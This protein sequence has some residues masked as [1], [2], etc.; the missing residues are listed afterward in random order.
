MYVQRYLQNAF[1]FGASIA[2]VTMKAECEALAGRLAGT[3]KPSEANKRVRHASA[4][5]R[6]LLREPCSPGNFFVH[7]IDIR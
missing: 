6:W 2:C 4:R 5:V 3:L 7:F 1:F